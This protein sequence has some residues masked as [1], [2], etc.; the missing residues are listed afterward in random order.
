[1]TFQIAGIQVELE[2]QLHRAQTQLDGE[3]K[4]RKKEQDETEKMLRAWAQEKQEFEAKAAAS[5]L[6]QA[7]NDDKKIPLRTS[8]GSA[9]DAI[10]KLGPKSPGKG[11]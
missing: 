7:V 8:S 11:K 9:W 3:K 2:Q 1:M 4:A 5:S 10:K 6:K